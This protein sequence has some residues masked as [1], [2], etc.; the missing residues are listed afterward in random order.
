MSAEKKSETPEKPK[1]DD[2]LSEL[3]NSKNK[4]IKLLHNHRIQVP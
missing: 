2:E 1:V 3:L 4:K